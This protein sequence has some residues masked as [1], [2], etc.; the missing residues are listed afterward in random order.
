MGKIKLNQRI[1]DVVESMRHD[2]FRLP[3]IQR[4]FVWNQEQI[5]KLMDSIMNDYPIGSF[6]AWK[7]PEGLRVRTRKFMEDFKTDMRLISNEEQIPS[8]SYLVLD[9]QQRLQSL[10]TSF[11]R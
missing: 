11:F 10:Y 7:P 9:G 5:F 1:F 3:S 2:E 4:S 8:S 6:L